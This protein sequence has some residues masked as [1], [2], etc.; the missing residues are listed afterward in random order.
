MMRIH[1]RF[2]EQGTV[3]VVSLPVL[4]QLPGGSG[5]TLGGTLRRF[6]ILAQ[7]WFSF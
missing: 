2:Q 4:R 7:P 3:T 1:D 6:P 5:L